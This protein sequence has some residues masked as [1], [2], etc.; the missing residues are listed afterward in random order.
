MQ[1]RS[2]P[3]RG[4][5]RRRLSRPR[6][7]ACGRLSLLQLGVGPRLGRPWVVAVLVVGAVFGS[8]APALAVTPGSATT[9]PPS[10]SSVSTS[11]GFL[12][13]QVSWQASC[14]AVNGQPLVGHFWDVVM[15]A[16]GQD[17]SFSGGNTKNLG[18]VE[19]YSA[20]Q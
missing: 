15:S 4:I 12:S 11:S 19:S 20:V 2:S 9:D 18:G 17:G 6:G 16:Y 1:G 5:V 3:R 13:A 7:H 10:G 8:V 14:P